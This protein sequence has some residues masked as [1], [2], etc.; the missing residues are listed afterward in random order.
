MMHRPSQMADGRK[1]PGTL[2]NRRLGSATLGSA[3]RGAHSLDGHTQTLVGHQLTQRQ[4]RR[5]GGVQHLR[6][7]LRLR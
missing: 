4:S 6:V 2:L 5:G 1:H 3:Y 7:S